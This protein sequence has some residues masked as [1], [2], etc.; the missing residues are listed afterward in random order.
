[1]SNRTD[2]I[3]I[4]IAIVVGVSF[5]IW[6]KQA[7]APAPAVDQNQQTENNVKVND[8]TAG[9]KTY[10]NTDY[11]F[12]F[13]YPADIQT[14]EQK[15]GP[16]WFRYN[17]MEV[18]L[19]KNGEDYLN[20]GIAS[21]MSIMANKFEC[22]E[23]QLCTYVPFVPLPCEQYFEEKP[24]IYTETWNGEKFKYM[25]LNVAGAWACSE[26]TWRFFGESASYKEVVFF[27]P[28][29][30]RY[31]F[32]AFLGNG[33]NSDTIR[34][35]TDLD[36]KNLEELKVINAGSNARVKLMNQILSTF[37]FIN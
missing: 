14:K 10:R 15:S 5:Y 1:M 20:L 22:E 34:N 8:E 13:K 21:N 18:A 6:T 26:N 17:E 31:N 33:I 7:E 29:S 27:G 9:W 25:I 37:K 28:N 12:E 16:I 24:G 19:I 35:S 30:A 23:D 11:K 3:I 2:L 36:L 4:L 32:R